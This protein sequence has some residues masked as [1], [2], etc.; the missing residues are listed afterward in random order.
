MEQ[1]QQRQ[2]RQQ[3]EEG[4]I[5]QAV[6][7]YKPSTASQSTTNH[8]LNNPLLL[9]V[10]IVPNL[11]KKKYVY[12]YSYSLGLVKNILW[13]HYQTAKNSFTISGIC[14]FRYLEALN[15]TIDHKKRHGFDL[16]SVAAKNDIAKVINQYLPEDL[17]FE[18]TLNRIDL[19]KKY[20]KQPFFQTMSDTFLHF[21]ERNRQILQNVGQ[22]CMRFEYCHDPEAFEEFGCDQFF[23]G[24]LG[25]QYEKDTD[26]DVI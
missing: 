22:T 6:M 23:Y 14:H 4:K 8:L 25:H 12:W 20:T 1:R 19:S 11:E 3:H 5:H 18:T 24:E 17:Q 13:G 2:Q 21:I 7:K 10:K 26:L 15:E 9:F 16:I